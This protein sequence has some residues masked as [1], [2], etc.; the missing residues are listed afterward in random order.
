MC[1]AMLANVSQWTRLAAAAIA[2]NYGAEVISTTRR[3]D[4]AELL[5]SHGAVH[6]IVDEGQVA[7]QVRKLY[8][9]GVNK[10]LELV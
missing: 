10:V 1:C 4:R 6:V 3:A 2:R 7:G 8:P 9:H 5:T